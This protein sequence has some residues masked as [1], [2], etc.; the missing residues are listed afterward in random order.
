MYVS[1]YSSNYEDILPFVNNRGSTTL[2]DKI[3]F[4]KT[5][6]TEAMLCMMFRLGLCAGE[7]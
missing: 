6:L 4:K 2:V 5:T 1:V 7:K 3:S